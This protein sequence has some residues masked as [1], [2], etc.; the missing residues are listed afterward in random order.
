MVNSWT[1]GVRFCPLGRCA[2]LDTFARLIVKRTTQPQ[3]YKGKD[4]LE[5]VRWREEGIINSAQPVEHASVHPF[6]MRAVDVDGKEPQQQR[7][8]LLGIVHTVKN[9]PQHV[10]GDVLSARVDNNT[11]RHEDQHFDD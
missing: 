4:G 11:K 10:E 7:S 5:L 3:H 9:D 6:K 2:L 8:E 1:V